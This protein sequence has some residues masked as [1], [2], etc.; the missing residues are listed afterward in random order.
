MVTLGQRLFFD[1][2]LSSDGAHSCASCH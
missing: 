1:P 2:R